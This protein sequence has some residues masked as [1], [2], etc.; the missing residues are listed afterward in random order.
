MKNLGQLSFFRSLIK[1]LENNKFLSSKVIQYSLFLVLS[2]A[3]L[4][5]VVL[6]YG[7]DGYWNPNFI[8]SIRTQEYISEEDVDAYLG[9]GN[10]ENLTQAFNMAP[11]VMSVT[12]V[13]QQP[14]LFS[15]EDQIIIE[16]EQEHEDIVSIEDIT[17][18]PLPEGTDITTI[19]RDGT[20]FE[21][22][23]YDNGGVRT[24]Y[25][26]DG[27]SVEIH[28]CEVDN[29]VTI[30]VFGNNTVKIH[31]EA[32]PFLRA[33]E[34]EW[35]EE[36]GNDFYPIPSPGNS[37]GIGGYDCRM[38][39]GGSRLS[40]HAWGM[41]VD[42][43]PRTNPYISRVASLADAPGVKIIIGGIPVKYNPPILYVSNSQAT[44]FF[45]TRSNWTDMPE[46]FV[47][48]WR[49]NR[50]IWLGQMDAMHY[51]LGFGSKYSS[52]SS[53]TTT[54]SMLIIMPERTMDTTLEYNIQQDSVNMEEGR[55]DDPSTPD[56]DESLPPGLRDK[57]DNHPGK[58]NKIRIF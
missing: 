51:E 33:V 7:I 25:R 10:E 57:S 52:S 13:I 11:T 56:I 5:V 49:H 44:E 47:L 55:V 2:V 31:K 23:A 20:Q 16:Q 46:K 48:M 38:T 12:E 9:Y 34:E 4:V 22:W 15:P 27:T 28:A 32:V 3:F 6:M 41:A 54:N 21:K 19:P 58:K 1:S 17:S 29:I 14:E 43:N 53:T 50:W 30:K 18:E 24:F 40:E 37:Y 45:A 8:N 36:G 39:T 35:L 42:I 26:T